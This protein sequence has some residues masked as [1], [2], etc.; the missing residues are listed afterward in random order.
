[1]N[2]IQANF[3]EHVEELRRVLIR[4][5]ILILIGIFCSFL[6][7]N[8][9]LTLLTSPLENI[10]QELAS[11]TP[12][13]QQLLRHERLYND[14]PS[15][16]T[17]VLPTSHTEI[18]A[19]S[20]RA[21]QLDD[22]TFEIPPHGYLEIITPQSNRELAIFGPL[23]GFKITLKVCFWIGLVFSSPLW[24]YLLLQFIA[25][26]LRKNERGLLI[27]F[28]VLSI[29]FL[30]LGFFFAF[31]ITIPLAN[32][33]L[34]AF[35]SSIGMNLWSFSHYLDYTV[36]LLLANGLAFELGVIAL[37]LVQ[38]EIFTAE[39]MGKYRR[40][41]IL[42][43]FVI[44]AILTP[45]DVIT[46]ILLAIPLIGLYEMVILYARIL[47]RVRAKRHQSPNPITG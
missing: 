19:I 23:E 24:M 12:L 33:Y 34:F 31:K 41:T 22:K 35:N 25:P 16:V 29:L 11:G 15:N 47:E 38:L 1:M 46:Q 7:Y 27:P 20:E 8:P 18:Y 13:K 32:E 5:L 40:H 3:W 2:D 10:H 17:Y 36:I 21:R 39:G 26:A 43:S 30:S 37:F 45:P 14:G 44:A 6:F 4:S 42:V 28:L 9:I